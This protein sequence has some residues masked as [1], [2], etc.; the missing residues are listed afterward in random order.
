[1]LEAALDIGI[2][3]FDLADIYCYGK[4][5]KTF[6]QIW[7]TASNLRSQIIIQTK[8]GVRRHDHVPDT[9]QYDLSHENIFKSA[10][11][12]A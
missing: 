12:K 10:T 5:E 6:A 7:Q 4:A 9:L 8:C 3:H 1:M 11:G 2:T